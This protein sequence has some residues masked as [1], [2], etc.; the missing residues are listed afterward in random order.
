MAPPC[1]KYKRQRGNAGVSAFPPG[2]RLVSENLGIPKHGKAGT[3]KLQRSRKNAHVDGHS[4]EGVRF[5]QD[6]PQIF[7]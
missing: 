4:P 7:R 2:V 6:N 1:S 5:H 3:L